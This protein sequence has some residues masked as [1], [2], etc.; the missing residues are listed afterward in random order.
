M[1]DKITPSSELEFKLETVFEIGAEGGSIKI[2]RQMDG[3]F[4]NYIMYHNEFDPLGDDETLV[5]VKKEYKTFNQAFQYI[6][7]FPWQCLYILVV[8][9]DFRNTI[10]ERLQA[11][12][13]EKLS[14]PVE[15]LNSEDLND[16]EEIKENLSRS[17]TDWDNK[18]H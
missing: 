5:N 9:K 1:K 4:D 18:S 11:K 2:Y 15:L 17:S 14:V 12:L 10:T 3:S 8:H 6:E 7:R 16:I 13:K